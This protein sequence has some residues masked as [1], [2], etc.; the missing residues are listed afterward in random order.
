[1]SAY[2]AR[3]Q[4]RDAKVD[5]DTHEGVAGGGGELEIP[6]KTRRPATSSSMIPTREKPGTTPAGNRTPVRL[7]EKRVVKPTTAPQRV[8]VRMTKSRYEIT[9][10]GNRAMTYPFQSQP[11]KRQ[12]ISIVPLQLSFSFVKSEII[13]R[14]NQRPTST[15]YCRPVKLM[16]ENETKTLCVKQNNSTDEQIELSSATKIEVAGKQLKVE[17]KLI[18][19]MVDSEVAGRQ[20][21]VEHKLIM[22]MVDSEVAGKQLK[23]EHK[24]IMTMV[25]SEV[26]GRQLKVEHKLII[27]MVDSEVAGK[28]LK[29]EHKLIMTMVDSEVAGRQLKVEHKLIMT[30]VDSEVAGKQLKVEH[31]LIMTMVDSEVAGRQLKVEHKLIMTM[32][33]SEVAG[34]QLKVEHKLIMTMVDS[35]VA[36]KQLKVEHKLIMTMVDSE[37][38]GRQLKVEHKL[39]ITMV[40]S[41]VA[42]KQLKVEHKLIMTMVDSEVAGRQLKVEHKLIM[43]MVDSEVAGKQLKVE[44]KLIMTMVDSEVSGRQLKVEHKLI[45]TMVDSEVAGRQLKVEH[46]LIMTM[47]DSEVAGRQLKVEHKLIITMVDSEV[48]G[49]Q[50]KVEHKLIMTMVDSEVAG[51]QLKVEHKLIMTMVDSEVAGRQLKVEHKLI[52]TMVDSEVAGRQLKVEHKLIMTM[53]DSEVCSSIS[54]VSVERFFV[55]GSGPKKMNNI[56]S[57]ST[58]KPRVLLIHQFGT[59]RKE[60]AN[61]GRSRQRESKEER[62]EILRRC[63]FE[64]GLLADMPKPG[65]GTSNE[66]KHSKTFVCINFFKYYVLQQF[67]VPFRVVMSLNQFDAHAKETA[68]LYINCT[69][70]ITRQLAYTRIWPHV[71][72][73]ILQHSINSLCYNAD[74]RSSALTFGFGIAEA[75]LRTKICSPSFVEIIKE[76]IHVGIGFDLLLKVEN[77]YIYVSM[78]S[79]DPSSFSLNTRRLQIHSSAKAPPGRGGIP[80]GRRRNLG[81]DLSDRDVTAKLRF[82]FG[83]PPRS[84]TQPPRISSQPPGE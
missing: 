72:A 65:G 38:A 53:V 47:V 42:G 80:R 82:V 40:D 10:A 78:T 46:K 32:V 84:S 5:I 77:S 50:L 24:L 6:E 13:L 20:L 70:G 15:R 76:N 59:R 55:C 49:R 33:D 66:G 25:D 48:A 73:A 27:T 79:H 81:N 1:M 11:D 83:Y 34:R 18:M 19:T 75:D 69:S 57:V 41:E 39:I 52:I 3:K 8:R 63:R 29:V 36:G 43:T 64:V 30:M 23:V 7:G 56:V 31:K 44:H 12:A 54:G 51:R 67:S 17:H 74:Y 58:A 60:L 45:M 16:F 37:V 21:K 26:A 2:D 9:A 71:R 61:K 68:T 62:K 4:Q 35:E 14:K 28:Q 22:T